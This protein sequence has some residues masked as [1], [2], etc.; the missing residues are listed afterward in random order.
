MSAILLFLH[1]DYSAFSTKKVAKTVLKESREHGTSTWLPKKT[2]QEVQFTQ[3]IADALSWTWKSWCAEGWGPVIQPCGLHSGEKTLSCLRTRCEWNAFWCRLPV[4]LLFLAPLLFPSPKQ[5]QRSKGHHLGITVPSDLF[6][7][8]N[9]LLKN[10]HF[11]PSNHIYQLFQSSSCWQ[12]CDFWH[13]L[14]WEFRGGKKTVSAGV[15]WSVF[16]WGFM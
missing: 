4:T 7:F 3:N 13:W 1:E 11:T 14:L 16:P 15:F 2:I 10:V 12:W 8:D 6:L 5:Y 9:M